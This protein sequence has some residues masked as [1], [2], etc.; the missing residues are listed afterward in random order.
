[1]KSIPMNYLWITL[2]G[3]GGLALG[4]GEAPDPIVA[5]VGSHTISAATLRAFVEKLPE[6]LRLQEQA[7]VVRRRYLQDLIDRQLLL[8]EARQRGLDTTEAART[9]VRDAVDNRARTLYRIR[10]ITSE[11]QVSPEETHSFFAKEGYDRERHLSAIL[12]ASR[13]ALDT[14]LAELKRGRP[15][16]EVA[17]ARSLDQRSAQRGGELGYIDR[18]MAPRLHVPPETFRTLPLGQVSEPLSAGERWHVVLFTEERAVDFEKYRQLIEARLFRERVAQAEE[19]HLERLEETLQLRLRPEGL[20]ELVEA[21][22]NRVLDSLAASPRPLYVYDRG[23]IS[24]G[25]AQQALLKFNLYRGLADSARAAAVLKRV[26]LHPFLMEEA[27]RRA[28]I[29]AE[30]EIR[31]LAETTSEDVLLEMLRKVAVTGRLNVSAEEARQYYDNNPEL[32]YHEEALWVQELLLSTEAEAGQVKEQL[33]RGASFEELAEH[34]LRKSAVEHQA[35]FHFHPQEKAIYPKLVPAITA[36]L[37]GQITGPVEVEGGYSVF[38]L[39]G[40]E[41]QQLEPFETAGR[42]ARALVLR[43]RETQEMDALVQH[44]RAQYSSQVEIDESELHRALPDALVG[45]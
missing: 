37:V 10:E 26:V 14:V 19:E 7:D 44:L 13:G 22:R 5:R 18:E 11:I 31:Q 12:V 34:S 4:C 2:L 27:A 24:V 43:Q 39:L 35:R 16:A 21:Y 17:R 42:R 3:L 45:N 32:F 8:M 28:D 36:A 41:K 6:G 15:F 30:P 20:K 29:Y 1:M 9:G 38:R 25:N 33:E 23:E 40:R